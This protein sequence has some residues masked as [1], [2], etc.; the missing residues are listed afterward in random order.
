MLSGEISGASRPATT[1]SGTS[2]QRRTL[3]IRASRA[4]LRSNFPAR[5][6]VGTPSIARVVTTVEHAD[7]VIPGEGAIRRDQTIVVDGPT[8]R[9]IVTDASGELARVEFAPSV[10]ARRVPL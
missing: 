6:T 9:T 5:R 4:A 3:G 8:A 1:G 7:L 10:V 2:G